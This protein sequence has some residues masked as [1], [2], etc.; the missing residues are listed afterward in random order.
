MNGIIIT[1]E[2]TIYGGND[3][4]AIRCV[5]CGEYASHVVER[6]KFPLC[7]ACAQD[8][9]QCNQKIVS[10][11]EYAGETNPVSTTLNNNAIHTQRVITLKMIDARYDDVAL[12]KEGGNVF[13][14]V[15]LNLTLLPF[16]DK[17][18]AALRNIGEI[19]NEEDVDRNTYESTFDKMLTLCDQY[20]IQNG[21]L[22][23]YNGDYDLT[24]FYN[25]GEN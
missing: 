11:A 16:T 25:N 3:G 2:K 23:I 4:R 10:L 1:E 22:P 21:F 15:Y 17:H 13:T 8:L 5:V 20:M 14:Q 6:T 9:L 12:M 19:V 24:L 7:S 18:R